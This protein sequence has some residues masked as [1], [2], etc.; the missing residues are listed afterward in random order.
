MNRE[1]SKAKRY[2]VVRE[3]M[4]RRRRKKGG[5]REREREREERERLEWKLTFSSLRAVLRRATARLFIWCQTL[6]NVPTA[7]DGCARCTCSFVS[8][9]QCEVQLRKRNSSPWMLYA[10]V[11]MQTDGVFG[12]IG[13]NACKSLW[14]KPA[15]YVRLA[16]VF[17]NWFSVYRHCWKFHGSKFSFL[18]QFFKLYL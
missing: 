3:A 7:F 17:T 12:T 4:K 10:P 18:S 15:V 9:V 13:E 8:H 2:V 1:K 16:S 11:R 14:E 6:V 5:W